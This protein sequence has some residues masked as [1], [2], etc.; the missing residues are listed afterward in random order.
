[1]HV[2][3]ACCA[4]GQ[5]I[6]GTPVSFHGTH[7]ADLGTHETAR[8]ARSAEYS[9]PSNTSHL[10]SSSHTLHFPYTN[11]LHFHTP[12]KSPPFTCET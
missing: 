10:R 7:L 2:A 8:K 12:L 5:R 11:T 4:R 3:I 6:R 9:E 1:M